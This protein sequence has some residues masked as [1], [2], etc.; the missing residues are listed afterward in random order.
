MRNDVW[1]IASRPEGKSVVTSKWL[2]K[3]KHV[4]D[5]SVEKHKAGFVARGFSQRKGVDYEETFALVAK[6][7]SI[8]A[9]MS[10]ASEMGWRLGAFTRC[11]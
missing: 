5:S 11:M 8:R 1:E 4:A 2:Y 6:Y 3:V 7:S 10:I 9:V